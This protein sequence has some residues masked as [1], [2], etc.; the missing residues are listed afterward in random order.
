MSIMHIETTEDTRITN[1]TIGK[2]RYTAFTEFIPAIWPDRSA[3]QVELIVHTGMGLIIEQISRSLICSKT[4]IRASD[5]I[6]AT[7]DKWKDDYPARFHFSQNDE[8][9]LVEGG[10]MDLVP[11]VEAVIEVLERKKDDR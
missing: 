7:I 5:A 11:T 10:E 9:K 6:R 4:T 2:A 8:W 1:G 3:W